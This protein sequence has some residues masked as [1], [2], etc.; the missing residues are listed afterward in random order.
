[1]SGTYTKVNGE[2]GLSTQ[3]S[4]GSQLALAVCVLTELTRRAVILS[5]L[6][7]QPPQE[8]FTVR[9]G[10]KYTSDYHR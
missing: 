6:P 3:S 8:V 7:C 2:T 10:R 5:G 1:M 4:Y 9:T